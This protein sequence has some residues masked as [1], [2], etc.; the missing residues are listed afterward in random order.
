MLVS[1]LLCNYS[2]SFCIRF[3][4]GLLNQPTVSLDS[5]KLSDW[6]TF[7][8]RSTL[9][10]SEEHVL[11]RQNGIVQLHIYVQILD[12]M[13][14]TCTERRMYLIKLYLTVCLLVFTHVF[15]R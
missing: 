11:P 4:A 13:Q 14:V 7:S 3:G 6:G 12:V 2:V 1:M 10:V 5:L 9:K 8:E 15:T